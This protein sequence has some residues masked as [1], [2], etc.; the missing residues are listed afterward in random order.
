MRGKDQDAIVTSIHD[1]MISGIS[2]LLAYTGYASELPLDTTLQWINNVRLIIL[3]SLTLRNA[4]GEIICSRDL[5]VITHPL[6]T[7]FD[8][9]TMVNG[10]D[11]GRK[12][13]RKSADSK[14]VLSTTDLGL[15]SSRGIM[16]E[17]GTE[18]TAEI[19]LK[20]KVALRSIAREALGITL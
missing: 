19:L 20:P 7:T 1:E 14:E 10:F 15:K 3:A 13:L 18:Y 4:I 5:E 11:D 16:K 8:P 17:Y 12:P 9:K 6:G 2:T